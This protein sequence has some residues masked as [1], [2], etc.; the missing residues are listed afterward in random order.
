[1][2]L[3][4]VIH[5]QFYYTNSVSVCV[6]RYESIGDRSQ[7]HMQVAITSGFIDKFGN[8]SAIL[9]VEFIDQNGESFLCANIVGFLAIT[10]MRIAAI[11]A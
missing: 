10:N 2:Q 5:T 4:S 9:Q 6:C 1:M 7:V 8:E 3:N 11:T